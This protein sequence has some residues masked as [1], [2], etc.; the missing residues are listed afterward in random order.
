VASPEG[1]LVVMTT[2]HLDRL[3]PALIRPGRADVKLCFGNATT[4]QA[5]RLF[6]RFFPE[7][8]HRSAEFAGRVEDRKYSMATL[9]DY[10][11][12]HRRNPEDAIQRAHEIGNL[13][14]NGSS[15]PASILEP[16]AV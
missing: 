16:V 4:D 9:Q 3:D 15:P 1:R 5:R 11:M 14:T 2:N 6:A 10:L 7:Q 12:L 8:A 13:Q